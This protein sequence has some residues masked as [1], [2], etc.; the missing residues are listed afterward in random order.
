[1]TILPNNISSIEELENL[2]N[3]SFKCPNNHSGNNYNVTFF[4]GQNDGQIL[5]KCNCPT[6]ELNTTKKATEYY[7]I[8]T[9]K[10]IIRKKYNDIYTYLKDRCITQES[11]DFFNLTQGID[12]KFNDVSLRIPCDVGYYFRLLNKGTKDNFKGGFIEGAK[13][14]IFNTQALNYQYVFICEGQLDAISIHQ[15]KSDVFNAISSNSVSRALSMLLPKDKCYILAID[16][17][18]Q[19]DKYR[20]KI[21]KR[22]NIKYDLLEVLQQYQVKDVNELLIKLKQEQFDKVINDFISKKEPEEKKLKH[23]EIGDLL[24]EKYQIKKY[25]SK[26]VYY[27]NDIY[28]FS[29]DDTNLLKHLCL[30]YNQEFKNTQR[31]EIAN[32]IKDKLYLKSE[33]KQAS[34]KYIACNN[35]ILNINTMELQPFN[36]DLVFF[37]KIPYDFNVNAQSKLLEDT[38]NIYSNFNETVKTQ[39]LECIG[40]CCYRNLSKFRK[41]FIFLGKKRSGKSS[42]LD[43]ITQLIGSYNISNLELDD[44]NDRFKPVKMFNKLVNIGDDIEDKIIKNTSK[45]KKIISGNEVTIEEKNKPN[46]SYKNYAT[47]IFSANNLPMFNDN[48]LHD[49]FIV[50]PFTNNL[51]N[52]GAGLF[53]IEELFKNKQFFETLLLKSILAFKK[54]LERGEFTINTEMLKEWEY[55]SDPLAQFINDYCLDNIYTKPTNYIFGEYQTFIK[56][57]NLEKLDKLES[58]RKFNKE[59]KERYNVKI[60][61]RNGRKVFIK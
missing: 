41:S 39:I 20:D 34:Y 25:H 17:D 6:C 38:L 37:N 18:E 47:M 19:S 9:P 60:D 8:E 23:N 30:L 13:K 54:V 33:I 1:M 26:V 45:I 27:L 42:M 4:R 14:G 49:R 7:Q 40:Y 36:Q 55:A 29:D 16:N 3:K 21:K 59:I 11:I 15:C 22:F 44:L 10:R 58:I 28:N 5:L 61:T 35:G 31:L 32:H 2:I 46:F 50:I 12:G 51:D 24:I 57:N 48:A 52:Y 43:I 53:D 56:F